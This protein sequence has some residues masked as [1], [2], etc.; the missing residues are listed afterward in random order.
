VAYA[1]FRQFPAASA[2]RFGVSQRITSSTGSHND[3]TNADHDTPPAPAPIAGQVVFRPQT[4]VL[5]WLSRKQWSAL[6]VRRL[7]SFF[8]HGV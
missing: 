3:K 4:P 1:P 2:P 5:H 7:L 8:S 6:Q